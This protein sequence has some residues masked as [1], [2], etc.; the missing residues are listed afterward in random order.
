ML[1][2]WHMKQIVLPN[3]SPVQTIVP[4][5]LGSRDVIIGQDLT[6]MGKKRFWILQHENTRPNTNTNGFIFK[7]AD[8]PQY[9]HNGWHETPQKAVESILSHKNTNA[10]SFP[11]W[12]EAAKWLA[13]Q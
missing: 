10:Y 1:L 2:Y 11:N 4:A 12:I 13:A 9:G 5:D 8:N 7:Q 6:P 3:S